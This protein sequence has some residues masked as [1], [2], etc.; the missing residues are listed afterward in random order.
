MTAIIDYKAGNLTSVKNALAAIGAESTVTSDPAVIR[1]ADHVI[2]PGVGAAKSAM[3]NLA[4][5]GLVDTVREAAASGKPFLGICL[6]MQILF[7]HSEEDGGVNL[8]GVL[9]GRVRRFPDVP[10]F[11]VPEIGWNQVN[12][13]RSSEFGVRSL[14]EQA[15]EF[16]F[17]HSYYAELGPYT[18]G[19][20]EYAGVEFTSMV[21]KGALLACQF[22]PEKSGRIGLELLKEFLSC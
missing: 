19:R 16:Y 4:S 2:F 6:G 14:G 10:G 21:R 5:L 1:A 7:E 20:T 17:V 13:V 15:R 18:V 22:H 11:K 9:P 8:L 3:E 12:I